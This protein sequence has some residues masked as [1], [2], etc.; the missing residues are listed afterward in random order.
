MAPGIFPTMPPSEII[1]YLGTW[2]IA[3]SHEQLLR[4]TSDFVEAVYYACLEHVTF[5]SIETVRTSVHVR[6]ALASLDDVD[7]VRSYV[8]YAP[9]FNSFL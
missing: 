7:Q 6:S 9:V 3:I 4:P 8:D 1:H 5:T 2:G